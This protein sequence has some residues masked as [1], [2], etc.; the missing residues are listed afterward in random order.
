MWIKGEKEDHICWVYKI[1]S[2]ALLILEGNTKENKD[3]TKITYGDSW[4]YQ[5]YYTLDYIKNKQAVYI[6]AEKVIE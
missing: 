1:N 2:I 6:Y 5:N 4:Y 3:Y